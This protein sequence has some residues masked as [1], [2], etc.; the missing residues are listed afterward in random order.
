M[1]TGLPIMVY[2]F[3]DDE[4]IPIVFADQ[5]A[6][7]AFSVDYMKQKFTEKE[8]KGLDL[9]PPTFVFVWPDKVG[10]CEAEWSNEQEKWVMLQL[11]YRYLKDDPCLRYSM[12]SETWVSRR[13][14]GDGKGAMQPRNDPNHVDGAIVLTME[15]DVEHIEVSTWEVKGST[16]EERDE[17]SSDNFS[18]RMSELMG[19]RGSAAYVH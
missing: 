15:R 13:K 9:V 10:Y 1:P 7:H 4:G 3:E 14:D 5:K 2:R 19:D 17:T 16:L 18:G 12:F 6:L 11:I 8:A